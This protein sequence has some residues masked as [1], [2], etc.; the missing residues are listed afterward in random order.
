MRNIVA[1]QTGALSDIER[2]RKG[3]DISPYSIE[4]FSSEFEPYI[5]TIDDLTWH[6]EDSCLCII[7]FESMIDR[8]NV[9]FIQIDLID[10]TTDTRDDII[11]R[12]FCFEIRIPDQCTNDI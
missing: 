4:I 8:M 7:E 9:V 6:E 10:C 3:I 12:E 1:N 11:F 5:F 2:I